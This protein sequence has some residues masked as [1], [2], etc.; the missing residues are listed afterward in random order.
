MKINE[1]WKL[2]LEFKKWELRLFAVQEKKK[3]SLYLILGEDGNE[4]TYD[5]QS[6][7]SM[8]SRG[9]S[10]FSVVTGASM[11]KGTK[12]PKKPKNLTS[13]VCKEGSLFEEEWLVDR[14][15]EIKIEES[16]SLLVTHLIDSLVI[17]EEAD[18][19]V[20][21]ITQYRKLGDLIKRRGS[22]KSNWVKTLAQSEFET[23]NPEVADLYGHIDEFQ[24]R[25][26]LENKK[27]RKEDKKGAEEKK[28]FSKYE[29][30]L[31]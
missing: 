19:A 3:N 27:K 15:N 13:R 29:F 8:Y 21:I 14:L 1:I 4:T 9:S 16:E 22:G 11:V 30:L 5:T 18:K 28:I 23:A 10:K 12:K 20:E 25:E 26:D 17:F 7:F 2:C 31:I 24:R 6:E